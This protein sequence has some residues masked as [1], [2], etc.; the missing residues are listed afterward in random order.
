M[1]EQASTISVLP[2]PCPRRGQHAPWVAMDRDPDEPE[3]AIRPGG[4]G[5]RC[6]VVLAALA[7]LLGLTGCLPLPAGSPA[8]PVTAPAAVPT[9]TPA[10]PTPVPTPVP[11]VDPAAVSA[12]VAAAEARITAA[13]VDPLCLRLEDTDDDGTPEW[14]GVYLQPAESPRL[15]GFVLDGERWYDLAPPPSDEETGLGEYPA[16]ELEV[17]DVNADGRTEL[18]LWGHAGPSTAY[19]LLFVWDGARYA[20]IAAFEGEGGVRLEDTDGD[21]AEEVV[22]GLRPD[23]SLVRE[24]VY[25]W[26]GHNYAW[27]WDR[28]AW[29]YLDRPHAH[30]TDT[31]LHALASFYLA[32]D[33]R[34]LPGAYSLLSPAAQAALG[35]DGWA[36]GFA[37]TLGVQVGAAQVVEQGEGGAVVIAQVR[38]ID[39]VQGRAVVT[40]YDVEWRLVQTGAGWRLE[41]GTSQLLEQWEVPYYR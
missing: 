2:A 41:S 18:A 29:F 40:V 32:L 31:P 15:L 28:Y 38:A 33:D 22:V 4:R 11:A 24:I 21:L 7:V 6:G 36:L 20:V 8:A 3:R 19:L 37:T 34:D 30:V 35:Y 9:A 39:N 5:G 1:A 14:V 23:G 10:L 26:D 12:T 17:R 25:T 13:G 16:C 27:T